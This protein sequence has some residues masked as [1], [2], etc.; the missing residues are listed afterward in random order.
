MHSNSA[1]FTQLGDI[2]NNSQNIPNLDAVRASRTLSKKRT[3]S[4]AAKS[5]L[6]SSSKLSLSVSN[7][8]RS[9]TSNISLSDELSKSISSVVNGSE[10]SVKAPRFGPKLPHAGKS[11]HLYRLSKSKNHK[12]DKDSNEIVTQLQGKHR[13]ES[14]PTITEDSGRSM[15]FTNEANGKRT[16]WIATYDIKS[17]EL[18][19]P[20]LKYLDVVNDNN[21]FLANQILTSESKYF[22]YK[23]EIIKSKNKNTENKPVEL[24]LLQAFNMKYLNQ[25]NSQET[26]KKSKAYHDFEAP[27]Y[28]AETAESPDK[29]NFDSSNIHKVKPLVPIPRWTLEISDIESKSN[30]SSESSSSSHHGIQSNDKTSQSGSK[31]L[32]KIDCRSILDDGEKKL[33]ENMLIRHEAHLGDIVKHKQVKKLKKYGTPIIGHDNMAKSPKSIRRL[34]REED[35][36]VCLIPFIA[37]TICSSHFYVLIVL[38]AKNI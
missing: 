24:T 30:P 37:L 28:H 14:N 10:Y 12:H 26:E 25:S 6:D 21:M 32:E 13:Q 31:T 29:M 3:V 38:F 1:K 8:S 11:V 35:E 33:K 15:A 17:E 18:S 4:F 20:S 27:Y 7:I 23:D 22:E 36:V 34:E 5:I 19:Y 16:K 2:S 9:N